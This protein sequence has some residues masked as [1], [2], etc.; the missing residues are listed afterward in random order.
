MIWET[1][2]IHPR[3]TYTYLIQNIIVDKEYVKPL[4]N[5]HIHLLIS[6]P[7]WFY[8]H[9]GLANQSYTFQRMIKKT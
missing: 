9:W 4:R 6:N 3:P 7:G 8:V 5:C 2:F 1:I